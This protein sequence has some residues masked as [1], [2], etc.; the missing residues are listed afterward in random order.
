[1]L[2]HFAPINHVLDLSWGRN[3]GLRSVDS[4]AHDPSTVSPYVLTLPSRKAICADQHR[5]SLWG[6]L[7]TNHGRM[8]AAA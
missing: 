8:N 7:I 3:Q 6:T 1:M 5:C 2:R 4:S